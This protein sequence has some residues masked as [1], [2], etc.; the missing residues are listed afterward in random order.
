MTLSSDRLIC[1]KTAHTH[2]SSLT[3]K[4]CASPMVRTWETEGEQY[5]IR[6]SKSEID[7]VEG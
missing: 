2:T 6:Y 4:Q 7:T 5:K 3:H 1:L